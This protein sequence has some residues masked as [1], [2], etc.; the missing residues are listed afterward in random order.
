[1]VPFCVHIMLTF[2]LQYFNILL[3]LGSRF[4]ASEAWGKL[5]PF[6]K[7]HSLL[8][9]AKALMSGQMIPKSCDDTSDCLWINGTLR[10]FPLRVTFSF[11]VASFPPAVSA[12]SLLIFL[13]FWNSLC[14]FLRMILFH[15]D[16]CGVPGLRQLVTLLRSRRHSCFAARCSSFWS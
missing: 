14:L 1:M 9:S 13:L 5:L 8:T 4:R 12:A 11:C 6:S 15:S 2:L 10:L 3:K 7:M 16:S